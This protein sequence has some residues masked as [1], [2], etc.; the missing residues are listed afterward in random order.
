MARQTR[1]DT[2]LGSGPGRNTTRSRASTRSRVQAKTG[3]SI[4]KVDTAAAAEGNISASLDRTLSATRRIV[5]LVVAL[6][7]LVLSFAPSVWRY[8]QQ[9]QQ[10]AQQRKELLLSQE[11]IANQQDRIARWEDPDY[12]KAQARE[13][14]GW[15]VPGETG[16]VVIGADGRP[17]DGSSAITANRGL[18]TASTLPWWQQMWD[19]VVA[20]DQIPSKSEQAV[21]RPTPSRIEGP[22]P[23]LSP[24][25][26][27][28]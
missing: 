26:K 15:V 5:I 14:L 6:A 11:R 23:S 2:R 13:R 4:G 3:R 19:S 22:D 27:P 12:V 8:Y 21:P 7:V 28:S 10:I 17:V 20:A 16:W 25:S 18:Q 24:T 1:R 9:R